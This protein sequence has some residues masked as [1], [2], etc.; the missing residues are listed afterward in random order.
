MICRLFT[1]LGALASCSSPVD[2]ARPQ[3]EVR[4]SL[5]FS[6]DGIAYQ[7]W[8]VVPRKTSQ[9]IAVQVP[10]NAARLLF[11]TCHREEI[12]SSPV[13]DW[14]TLFVPV[15]FLENW[16][17]CLATISIITQKGNLLLGFVDFASNE[18]LPAVSYCNGG[19]NNSTGGA[20][21]CQ[22]REGLTQKI[23]FEQTDVQGEGGNGCPSLVKDGFGFQYT[24]AR[25][26]CIYAFRSKDGKTHRLT[27]R[28]Y[29]EWEGD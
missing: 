17:S 23:T 5:S 9:R 18:T 28:G 6:V 20:S 1:I 15:Q 26:L 3:A 4:A 19:R 10:T 16:G 11:R 14:S 25:G 2:S 8:A 13:R 27:T 24:I 29:T 21:F 12:Y 22:A 7:S